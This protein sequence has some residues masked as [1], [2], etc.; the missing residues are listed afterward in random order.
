MGTLARP[1]PGTHASDSIMPPSNTHAR[2][3]P[4]FRA[5][6]AGPTLSKGGRFRDRRAVSCAA[7]EV[8]LSR[9]DGRVSDRVGIEDLGIGN[10]DDAV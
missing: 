1:V 3:S 2:L 4:P 8:R 9:G 5:I 6:A 7:Q 10:T